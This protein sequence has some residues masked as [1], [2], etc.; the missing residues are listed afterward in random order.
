MPDISSSHDDAQ[1]AT[2]AGARVVLLGKLAGMSKRDALQLLRAQGAV[3]V[4]PG[5][6]SDLIVVGE[7]ELL[8]DDA[9][10]WLSQPASSG[11]APAEAIT[12]TQL[13]QRLGL[14][15]A[16]RNVH[17]LYTPAMLA[18]LLGVP[19]AVI[20]RWHRRGLIVP[21]RQVRRLPYFDFQE[22]ATAR[23]LAELL[24][25]GAKPAAIERQLG[26]LKRWLPAI[27]RPLAQLS[28][29]VEGR[30]LL[31]RQGDGL[32]DA[33]GQWRFDFEAEDSLPADAA[34]T[35]P[36]S[37]LAGSP[38]NA[39][40][41]APASPDELCQWAAELEEAGQLD[42]AADAYRAA[43]VA[44][45]PRPEICFQ[46]AELLYR[47][48]EVAAACERYYM[49]VE[50]DEDYV[51]A[52]ANLGCVLAER[53]RPELAIAAFEGALRYHGD[54]PDAHFHLARLL[55][56]AGQ[57]G[58][59]RGHWES[60]LQLAADSPWADTARQRLASQP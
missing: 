36:F 28:V 11:A 2:L 27:A 57:H 45:G 24:T 59:A 5:Q 31:L 21:A 4:D 16:E 35:V 41:A 25:S 46:L 30:E 3:C 37:P 9:P 58:E 19:V 43:L 32:V 1:A 29:I 47:M 12:E 53:G 50:L 18:D 7:Q 17:R 34:P 13:W 22:V 15:D 8:L 56:E 38:D 51:E 54:Y 48:G 52:R 42:Q 20:R 6:P 39:S 44:G 14:V 55:D 49:A 60:F 23:R 40:L 33:A 26:A 10:E